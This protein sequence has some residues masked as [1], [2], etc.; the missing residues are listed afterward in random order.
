MTFAL[1]TGNI[2][3]ILYAQTTECSRPFEKKIPHFHRKYFEFCVTNRSLCVKSIPP[4]YTEASYLYGHDLCV[5]WSTPITLWCLVSMSI[6]CYLSL[7]LLISWLRSNAC[8]ARE[9]ASISV[10]LI[11]LIQISDTVGCLKPRLDLSCIAINGAW[12][13][14][15]IKRYINTASESVTI[16]HYVM[17]FIFSYLHLNACTQFGR[18]F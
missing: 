8:F 17:A 2:L 1:S 3:Y 5:L 9:L 15:T 10:F 6:C 11:R 18:P 16:R 4:T 13:L 12:H 7:Q 14:V